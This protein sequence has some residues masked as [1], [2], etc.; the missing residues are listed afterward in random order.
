M[1]TEKAANSLLFMAEV[2]KNEKKYSFPFIYGAKF[3]VSSKNN[4][5]TISICDNEVGDN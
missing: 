1:T 4:D 3:V 5:L 2:I